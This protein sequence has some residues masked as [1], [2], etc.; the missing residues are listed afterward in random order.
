MGQREIEPQARSAAFEAAGRE[1]FRPSETL[2]SAD[3]LG[4][5]LRKVVSIVFLLSGLNTLD[6]DFPG[7]TAGS[8][9][10]HGSVL[11]SDSWGLRESLLS[12]CTID[13][14]L[15][16]DVATGLAGKVGTGR[17]SSG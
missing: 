16:L 13:S 10:G 5:L 1:A 7:D 17:E 6:G 3:F 8:V 11:E 14:E 15:S 9:G 4:P 12:L 2:V